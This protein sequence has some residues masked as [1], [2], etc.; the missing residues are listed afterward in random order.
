MYYYILAVSFATAI[1]C[2]VYDDLLTVKGIKSG[3]ALEANTFWGLISNKPSL[4][5]LTLCGWA[6]IAILCL[7]SLLAHI[8][9]APAGVDYGCLG[10]P[11]AMGIKHIQGG[12][13][14]ATLMKG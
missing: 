1:G 13:Q 8:F 11:I 2:T 4:L 14:W 3:V 10:A 7:P 6:E 5:A 12:R 9:H